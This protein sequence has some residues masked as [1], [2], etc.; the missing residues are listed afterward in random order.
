MRCIYCEDGDTRV[1]DSRE[2]EGR[3]R[4]R[5]ECSECGERFTTYEKAEDLEVKVEKRSGEV[6]EF[7]EDKVRKGVERA[8]NK[9]SVDEDDVEKILEEVKNLVRGRSRVSSEC[10]GDKVKEEL[11]KR[12]EVAYI[13]FASVYDSFDDVESFKKEVET[14]KSKE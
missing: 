9:T 5:R 12:D 6:E 8:V 10:I 2:S 3:V 13:R 14:L 4:R 11:Q 1:I 7:D